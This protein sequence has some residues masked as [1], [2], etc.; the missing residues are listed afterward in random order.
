MKGVHVN[1]PLLYTAAALIG[2][3]TLV[4]CASQKQVASFQ[5]AKDAKTEQMFGA[6]GNTHS[7]NWQAKDTLHNLKIDGRFLN[8]PWRVLSWAKRVTKIDS[9]LTTAR[10]NK[11]LEWVYQA[12]QATMYFDH[13]KTAVL[14]QPESSMAK[15]DAKIQIIPYG[16]ATNL[17]STFVIG[18]NTQGSMQLSPEGTLVCLPYGQ[19]RP[20]LINVGK[21]KSGYYTIVDKG[22]GVLAL[23]MNGQVVASV[24][25]TRAKPE[26]MALD[27]L[28]DIRNRET[29]ADNSVG[30]Q[31]QTKRL[32]IE[33]HNNVDMKNMMQKYG[34]KDGLYSFDS[35]IVYPYAADYP[36]YA[37]QQTDARAGFTVTD[38]GA[39]TITFPAIGRK[40]YV[41][42]NYIGQILN[43]GT[44]AGNIGIL[45][46]TKAGAISATACD[47]FAS[48]TSVEKDSVAFSVTSVAEGG[49]VTVLGI[50]GANGLLNATRIVWKADS[51][52]NFQTALFCD[53]PGK[54][55]AKMEQQAAMVTVG[56]R[57]SIVGATSVEAPAD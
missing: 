37:D 11:D 53:V 27:T 25:L 32:T 46:K 41:S 30:T 31:A 28:K 26:I 34:L 35:T 43:K 6:A 12:S 22:E 1:K 20:V 29:N 10:L 51:K 13:E 23:E 55:G 3:A 40:V 47:F 50:R 15:K 38:K 7:I 48:F 57:S 54:G 18:S 4:G 36:L 8:T 5:K 33:G 9:L 2:V 16:V 52:G 42:S 49:T 24:R 44:A 21:D 45:P 14:F 17:D 19:T 56:P 39:A